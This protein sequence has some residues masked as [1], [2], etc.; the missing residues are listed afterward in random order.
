MNSNKV[1]LIVLAFISLMLTVPKLKKES[2]VLIIITI[3]VGYCVTRNVI[4]SICV[5]LILGNIYVS[6]NNIP[7]QEVEQEVEGFKSSSKKNK[8]LA[9]KT[10]E[11]FGNDD[12]TTENFSE[13]DIEEDFELD[14]KGSFY[15]NYKSLTPKQIKGLNSDTK[16]LIST[17]KQLIET[18]NNM[19][20]ALKDGK[21]ILDTFK[22]YFG[23]EADIGKAM[24]NFKLE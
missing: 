13:S 17:Q 21:Q 6:L 20:P 3:A 18:L 12:L 7:E 19:G 22:N 23:N 16:N 2:A 11:T 14:T 24:Q 8:K 5:G 1:I 4:V 9:K 10:K 15:E